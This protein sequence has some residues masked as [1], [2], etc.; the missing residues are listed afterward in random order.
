ML[1]GKSVVELLAPCSY[2]WHLSTR[3]LPLHSAAL[4]AAHIYGVSALEST[5]DAHGTMLHASTTSFAVVWAVAAAT[6]TA[7]PGNNST[8]ALSC[9][10]ALCIGQ[11]CVCP[12]T[13]V[14]TCAVRVMVQQEGT[15]EWAC[16]R[17]MPARGCR[18]AWQAC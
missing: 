9:A 6:A 8:S 15:V 3:A 1:Q 11:P 10:H 4:A 12:C 14:A 13:Q 7:L 17:L 18:M 16:T 5:V 2:A